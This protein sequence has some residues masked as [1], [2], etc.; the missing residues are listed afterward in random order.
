MSTPSE[1]LLK[2]ITER[3]RATANVDTLYGESR[4]IGDKTII[5][6]AKVYYGF[7][8]GG[9]EAQ[10]PNGEAS[11]SLPIG[12]GGG[13]GAGVS[14]RPVGFIVVSDGEVTFVRIPSWRGTILAGIAGVLAGLLL[15][16]LVS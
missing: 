3:I 1:A 4:Q 13:G 6:V 8:A 9:G 11:E 10:R 2:N 12:T 14:A 5:P 7:G 15:A 16:K